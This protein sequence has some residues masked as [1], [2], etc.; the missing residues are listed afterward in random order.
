MRLPRSVVLCGLAAALLP[1][2]ASA[3]APAND[4]RAGAAS[5][6][7]LPTTVQGTTAEATRAQDEPLGDCG[8]GG[9]SVWYAATAAE[10]GRIALRASAAGDLDM[11]VDV[12]RRVRSQLESVACDPSD[13]RG[14]AQLNFQAAKGD[15]F[16]IRVSEVVNSDPG[17]FTLHVSAPFTPAT[18]PGRLLGPGGAT[19]ILDRAENSDDAW[20]AVLRTGTTYRMRLSGRYDS[21]RPSARIYAPGTTAF[22]EA[23][24][25]QYLSCGSSWTFTPRPGEGGRYSV[26]IVASSSARLD[27]G[28][29]L[30][31]A[32]AGVDDT[33]P[34]V[35]IHNH[36]RA[37]GSL[38]G[39]RVD[40]LDLYRFTI[41]EHSQIVVRLATEQ[42]FEL[43]LLT[44]SGS[45]M[46]RARTEFARVLSP[47]RY[48]IAVR[49]RGGA[50]GRYTLR[51]DSRVL[52]HTRL[53]VERLGRI[54][55]LTSTTTPESP[56]PLT[57]VVERLDPLAGWLFAD[58]WTLRT[59]SGTATVTVRGS[60]GRYRAQ[61][62]FTGTRDAGDS[63]SRIVYFRL[64][65]LG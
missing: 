51:R 58:Q 42:D 19:G 29:H 30:Q 22:D 7:P 33:A 36:R 3:A 14:I 8:T 11:I 27:Q 12:F 34:G 52:T 26:L 4:N 61:S 57:I 6:D 44:E 45:V 17:T 47:G 37:R 38:Q 21:C 28:Y 56:G 49:A 60:H 18:P 50:S 24:P 25:V 5:L 20:S 10:A 48:F 59:A 41:A 54:A 32:E 46:G 39:D 13:A 31:V 65:R 23:T 64:K 15:R 43:E 63:E 55:Q 16:L 35:S 62:F 9:D 53:A 2:A 40:A 1:A